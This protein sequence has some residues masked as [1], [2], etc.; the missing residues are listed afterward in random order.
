MRDSFDIVQEE[1]EP[2]SK[3]IDQEEEA[4]TPSGIRRRFTMNLHPNFYN[5]NPEIEKER[6]QRIANMV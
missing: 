3:S 2:D 4:K 1:K 6:A 5:M